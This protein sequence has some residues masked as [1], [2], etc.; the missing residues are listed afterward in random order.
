MTPSRDFDAAAQ[1]LDELGRSASGSLPWTYR[2]STDYVGTIYDTAGD[3]ILAASPQDA[4]LFIALRPL[5][6]VL[7]DEFHQRSQAAARCDDDCCVDARWLGIARTL[8]GG[9]P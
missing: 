7:V 1:L 3:P 9:T 4:A 5:V 6:P 2:P 8:T